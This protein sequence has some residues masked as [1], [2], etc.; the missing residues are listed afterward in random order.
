[1]K[2]FFDMVGCRLN[3]AE[4][5]QMSRE[6]RQEGHTIVATMDD[7][8]TVVVNTCSVT[9]QAASDSRQKIRRSGAHGKDV[10]VTGC[11]STMEPA[12]AMLIPGVIQVVSNDNKDDLVRSYLSQRSDQAKN[13][14]DAE[15]IARMP[16]P[17][18]RQRT[19]AFI[20]VQDGCDNN[21]T[22]C[23]TN[24]ARGKSISRPFTQILADIHSAEN[25]GTKEIVLTGVHLGSWGQ[26]L[27]KPTHLTKL[28]GIILTETSIPRIRL[29]SLEPWDLDEK[30]L[31]LWQ[32][33]RLCKHLHLPLQ[34][35]SDATL[36]RML[37]KTTTSS[38]R[39][40]VS[41]A[42]MI[43][44]D[45]AITTDLICGFPGETDEEFE[46]SRL[47]VQEMAFSGGHVFSYSEREGTPA[48]RI[49][50]KVP[51]QV[52]KE[53]NAVLQEI[54]KKSETTFFEEN[55]SKTASVLW[56][57]TNV[58]SENGWRMSGLSS[59]YIK[60]TTDASSYLWNQIDEV[61]LDSLEKQGMS[62]TILN[63]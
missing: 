30:F 35:G 5:E 32:N 57:A 28:L 14:I 22:F 45:V 12:K 21:C 8:D 7:A 56:E 53:R 15:P 24:I 40:L 2:I 48:I 6:F 33:P 11:W 17:G 13:A 20:K 63:R 23:I 59:N 50:A 18:L 44:P 39:D 36:R 49:K 41:T 47:F 26:E 31:S 19:R 29:S 27:E 46:Q 4:I 1:M 25:G 16:L 10:V 60:V 37:R 38:F 58:R 43:I 3:Q 34:A 9:T 52:R 51:H 54:L 55:L 61:R 42:R 62:G